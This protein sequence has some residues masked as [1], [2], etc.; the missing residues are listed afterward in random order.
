MNKNL[1]LVP[2]R[3]FAIVEAND[4]YAIYRSAQ[5]MYGYEVK[6]MNRMLGLDYVVNLRA[7]SDYDESLIKQFSKKTQVHKVNV[8]DH[9]EPTLQQAERFMEF[10]SDCIKQGKK[11]LFHCEHGHGRT[12]TFCI[13]ARLAMGWTLDKAIKEEEQKFHYSFKH[14][15]QIEFLKKHFSNYNK[16]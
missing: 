1:G 16:N 11:V 7:E 6:W 14:P 10:I 4:K 3:N 2:L 15:A 9:H 13:L 12:S 8:P 5:P